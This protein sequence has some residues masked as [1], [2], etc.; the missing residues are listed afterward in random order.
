M[1]VDTDQHCLM[2]LKLLKAS[3]FLI[4]SAIA[5]SANV[6]LPDVISDSMVLQRDRPVPIWGMADPGEQVAI[7]FAGQT[8]T[9]VASANGKWLVRLNAMRANPTPAVMTILG[10][11]RIEL[12]D[13]LVGEV[14]LV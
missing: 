11:N 6:S 14:W 2:F 13:I 3:L 8:K 1:S 9:T 12:R 5:A 7:T 4:L 10:H